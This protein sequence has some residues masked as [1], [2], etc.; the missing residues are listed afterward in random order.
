MLGGDRCFFEADVQGIDFVIIGDF[1]RRLAVPSEVVDIDRSPHSFHR[2]I[3]HGCYDTF[4]VSLP[5]SLQFSNLNILCPSHPS[6]FG[7][8]L[9]FLLFC[10]PTF[11]RSPTAE[12]DF[13]SIRTRTLLT[14]SLFG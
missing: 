4:M 12:G 9:L 1:H 8:S 3:L 13:F 2:R 6:R 11:L 10:F 5:S 14:F 7:W